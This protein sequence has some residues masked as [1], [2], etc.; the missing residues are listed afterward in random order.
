MNEDTLKKYADLK[1][2]IKKLETEA[3]ICKT[4]ILESLSNETEAKIERDYGNFTLYQKRTYTYS[5]ELVTLI[6]DVKERKTQEEADGTATYTEA[7][8]LTFKPAR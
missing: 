6:D 3:D 8:V 2:Q 4:E 5:P 1:V 7:H